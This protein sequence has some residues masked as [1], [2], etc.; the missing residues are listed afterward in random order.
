MHRLPPF[1]LGQDGEADYIIRWPDLNV[2]AI[3]VKPSDE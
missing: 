1:F 2:S 3:K